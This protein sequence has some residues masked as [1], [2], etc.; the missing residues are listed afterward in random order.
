MIDICQWR[1]SIGSWYY[2]QI[3][4]H[5]HCTKKSPTSDVTTD[6]SR[7]NGVTRIRWI[8][9][10]TFSLVCGL[11]LLLLLSGDIELNPGPITGNSNRQCCMID[12]D[13][14]ILTKRRVDIK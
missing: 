8:R 13:Y 2:H 1:S 3:S 5:T 9:G 4:Y 11:L 6:N 12:Y 14:I 10:L 7:I